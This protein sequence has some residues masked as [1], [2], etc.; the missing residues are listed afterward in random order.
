MFMATKTIT[1]MD[2]AYDLLKARKLKKESFSEVIRR[3]LSKSKRPLT[4]FAG[5]WK[6]LDEKDINLIK[7]AI[8]KSREDSWRFRKEKLRI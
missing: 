6:F 2:D 3:E 1:I 8:L 5:K 4:D 7:E